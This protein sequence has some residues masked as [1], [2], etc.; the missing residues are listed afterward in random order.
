MK[1]A[2]YVVA[3]MLMYQ[4][5][6]FASVF[7]DKPSIAVL[8]F[9]TGNKPLVKEMHKVKEAIA[10]T[11]ADKET[12]MFTA[13][14][15]TALV[16]TNKFNVVERDRTDAV[17]K[18]LALGDSGEALPEKAIKMGQLLRAEYLVLGKVEVIEASQKKARILYSKSKKTTFQGH[19]VVN[20]EIVDTRNG[21]IAAAKKVNLQDVHNESAHGHTTLVTFIDTLKEKTV[22]QL[23][24]GIID[25][26]FPTRIIKVADNKVFL[27]TG[28]EDMIKVDTIMNVYNVGDELIDP[29]TQESL[30]MEEI[31]AGCIKIIEIRPKYIVAQIIEGEA[32]HILAGAICRLREGSSE[33]KPT[34]PKTPG[35]SSKP[36]SW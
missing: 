7:A 30:G 28:L 18:E 3:I 35:S 10:I 17:V 4:V 1:I 16:N 9:T 15:V 20:M 32:S 36:I 8:D 13:E 29:D 22:Q 33:N 11:W 27:T 5:I 2:R 12:N 26:I 24:N 25:G 14:L 21:K 34:E 31:Q 19:M 6:L 23:V